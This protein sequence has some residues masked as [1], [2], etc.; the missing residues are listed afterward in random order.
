MVRYTLFVLVV[1]GSAAT[2]LAAIAPQDPIAAAGKNLTVIEKN[3]V[4]P[5]L[6]PIY[7]EDCEHEDCAGEE[8]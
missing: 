6:G 7:V 5:V 4:F 1:I 8:V 3:Q 2:A